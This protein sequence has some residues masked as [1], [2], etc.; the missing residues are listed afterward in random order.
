VNF[1]LVWSDAAIQDLARIWTAVA[2]RN[3]VT[4]ASNQIDQMLSR[5]AQ[6]VGESRVGNERVAFADPLGVRFEV[7]VDDLMVTIGAVWLTRRA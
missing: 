5:D 7:V 1:T 6:R 3:A 2:D 4:R